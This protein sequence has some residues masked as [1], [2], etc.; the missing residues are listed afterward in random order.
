MVVHPFNRLTY[1]LICILSLSCQHSEDPRR[2][3]PNFIDGA[4]RNP[5]TENIGYWQNFKNQFMAYES[6][7]MWVASEYGPTP[8]T[9]VKPNQIM[10][11]MINHSTVLIQMEGLN[12]LTDPIFAERCSP[13]SFIGPKRVRNPGLQFEQLPKID[14][15]LI[16]HDHFDH[17]DL[18]LLKQ[19]E[20]RDQAQI[21]TGLGV[22]SVIGDSQRVIELDWWGRHSLAKH[23]ELHFVPTQ[24]FSGRG[25]FDRNSTLWGAF[26]LISKNRKIYFGGDSG[27]S[28][29]FKTVQEKFGAMDIAFLPVGAY[30]PHGVH[31]HYQMNP[32]QAVQA[33]RDLKSGQSFAI[34]YGT[35]QLAGEAIDEPI[36]KLKSELKRQNV[37]LSKFQAPKFGQTIDLSVKDAAPEAPTNP[38]KK[39]QV[40]NLNAKPVSIN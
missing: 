9:R 19:L 3:S 24:H 26:V 1:A 35:F 21:I 11:T 14:Y 28:S 30:S 36:I 8:P 6:W 25:F 38:E 2:Q 29:S 16:S 23:I 27:Y 17:L 13:F 32:G 31:N 39:K 18:E 40:Q 4:F 33:H 22:G 5:N 7:P 12:I 10:V 20:K 15:V 34:H 37:D